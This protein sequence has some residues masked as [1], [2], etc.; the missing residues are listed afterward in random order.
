MSPSEDAAVLPQAGLAGLQFPPLLDSGLPEVVAHVAEVRGA[1]TEVVGL[2]FATIP[3]LP[4]QE[5]GPVLGALQLPLRSAPSA[6]QL[7]GQCCLD[8][9]IEVLLLFLV[10]ASTF[11]LSAVV[12]FIAL[13]TF[14]ERHL[15]HCEAGQ[16]VLVAGVAGLRR[17]AP[18][19][20]D[21]ALQGL[22]AD[23]LIHRELRG[24]EAIDGGVLHYGLAERAFDALEGEPS[25]ARVPLA[26]HG[27]GAMVV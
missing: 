20:D 17:R 14:E 12:R 25:A 22:S 11:G 26:D 24:D 15:R 3:A 6:Y 18:L 16:A 2:S 27:L 4:A 1:E 23:L 7:H 21:P 5:L 13:R 10:D 19:L 9:V 8:V